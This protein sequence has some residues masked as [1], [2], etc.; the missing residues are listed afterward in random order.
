MN[1]Y[2]LLVTKTHVHPLLWAVIAIAVVT[3]RFS[4]V[5]LL[6]GIVLVHE[7]GHAV[8]AVFFSWRI[9]QITLLPFGGVAEMDEHGNR[10]IREEAIVTLCGPLQHVWLV[11]AAFFL[12]KLTWISP[13]DFQLFFNFNA[14][15][16]LFNLLPI[17]PLDGGKLLFL[18]FSSVCSFLQAHRTTIILSIIFL[19]CFAIITIIVSPT[20]LNIWIVLVFL[21][22]TLIKEWK[23]RRY[24]F[25][26][27]LLERYYGNKNGI[28]SLR[29]IKV[30]GKETVIAVLEHFQRGYKHPVIVE[31]NGQEKGTLDENELLYVCFTE[32]QMME[33]VGNLTR[34]N[35][36]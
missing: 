1:K 19:A 12:L 2:F 6:L 30:N 8:A 5:L 21:L 3:A 26:R 31:E 9:K 18:I 16:L 17:W 32:K 23:H 28:S 34:L 4:E 15:I 13:E 33:R 7:L 24:V 22:F 20:Q 29:P 11:I 14:M 10:P 35:W 25:M 27:F 36:R